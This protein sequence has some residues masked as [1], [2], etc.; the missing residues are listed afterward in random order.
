MAHTLA[1]TLAPTFAPSLEVIK[2][3][4]ISYGFTLRKVSFRQGAPTKEMYELYLTNLKK[5]GIEINHVC[6]EMT[7]GLHCHGVLTKPKKVKNERFRVRGWS[8]R[9]EELYDNLGWMSYITKD[10]PNEVDDI[11]PE[12]D[13]DP[14]SLTKKLFPPNDI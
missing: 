11:P 5:L 7:S 1:R 12:H 2:S 14:A 13:I 3:D 4:K 9:L 10:Q 6:Y 8:M